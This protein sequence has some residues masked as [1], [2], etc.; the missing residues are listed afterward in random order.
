MEVTSYAS[1]E[2]GAQA[3]AAGS[4]HDLRVNPN[5]SPSA[6]LVMGHTQQR[7]GAAA[8]AGTGAKPGSAPGSRPGSRLAQSY[9]SSDT[10]SSRPVATKYVEQLAA[11]Q[12]SPLG[13]V[14]RARSPYVSGESLSAGARIIHE[15]GAPPATPKAPGPRGCWPRVRAW[16]RALV[17]HRYFERVVIALILAN[18]VF[19]STWD[20]LD[21]DPNSSHNRLLDFSDLVFQ[22]LF[23]VEMVVKILALGLIRPKDAYL[24][25]NWNVI[26]GLLVV[27]GWV[28][29]GSSNISVGRLVR[30]LRPL[31]TIS[32]VPGLKL[33]INSMLAS[34]PQLL[35]V[36]GLCAFIFFMFGIVG[37]QL[38]GGKLSQRCHFPGSPPTV[39]DDDGQLCSTS[40]SSGRQCPVVGGVQTVCLDTGTSVNYGITNFD[41]I[42]TAFLTIFQ[43]IT[44][45]GWVDVMY[46]ISETMSMW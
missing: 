22:C 45:E 23:T 38:F 39:N 14:L 46:W 33:I 9:R 26:D 8:G 16:L 10:E 28:T 34:I 44:L 12:R 21:H 31:R 30:V 4:S 20:P 2:S 32:H 36:L 35:N 24:R 17:L 42:G 43:C 41:N 25:D 40:G 1:A 5:A 11:G 6:G 19:V 13:S 3:T 29:L 27:S 37:I 15:A 7:S 18:M